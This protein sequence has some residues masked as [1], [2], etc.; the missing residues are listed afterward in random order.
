MSNSPPIFRTGDG[1]PTL[2][3]DGGHGHSEKMHHSGGAL[4]ESLFVYHHALSMALERSWPARVLSVGLG[5]GYNEWITLAEILRRGGQTL[6]DWKI[7]SFETE[8]ILAESFV[9][10][11]ARQSCDSP[12]VEVY[13]E[14][15]ERVA[16]ALEVDAEE[17]RALGVYALQTKRLE[18]RGAF[19]DD[20]T[21]V[22]D[23]TCIFYDAYSKKMNADLWNETAITQSLN[24]CLAPSATLATY[25]ATGSL[26][27]A[28]KTLGFALQ[29]RAGFQGKRESTL[30]VRE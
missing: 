3:W 27:R 25:A 18:L 23:A 26:N 16:R 17:L 13:R 30:A 9:A 10:S 7:W 12:W 5:L 29:P 8:S 21:G 20:L 4:S 11:V 6:E 1:S 2:D 15:R 22:T 28:L 19:P 24:A 14:V